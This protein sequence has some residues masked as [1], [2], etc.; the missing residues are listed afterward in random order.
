MLLVL[1][2]AC[3]HSQSKI[4]AFYAVVCMEFCNFALACR[5]ALILRSKRR[6]FS[7]LQEY[8]MLMAVSLIGPEIRA[9]KVG[10]V[11]SLCSLRI[12]RER[13]P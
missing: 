5:R 1:R 7:P 2:T 11:P 13:A 8:V 4:N 12:I 3:R 10:A 6:A 9:V